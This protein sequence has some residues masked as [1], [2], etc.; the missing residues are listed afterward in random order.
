MSFLQY[1]CIYY[2]IL[3]N[4][5]IIHPAKNPSIHPS[6]LYL[7]ILPSYTSTYP[8][9]I[10]PIS[11]LSIL[12]TIHPSTLSVL[13]SHHF[14]IYSVLYPSIHPPLL[15]STYLSNH[16]LVIYPSNH[17]S[18]NPCIIFF[19]TAIVDNVFESLQAQPVYGLPITPSQ[20]AADVSAC[21]TLCYNQTLPPCTAIAF[22]SP[23]VTSCQMY[24]SLSNASLPGYTQLSQLA[25]LRSRTGRVMFLTGVVYLC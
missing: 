13:F 16:L 23:P 4:Q 18:I 1:Q 14:I 5:R 10:H 6:V 17:Q 21:A 22:T 9:F 19:F 7:S 25:D 20:T 15:Q 24:S 3:F 11:Q 12:I 8:L 2:I